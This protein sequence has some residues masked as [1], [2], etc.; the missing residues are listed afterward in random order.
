MQS[1]YQGTEGTIINEGIINLIIYTCTFPS[2]TCLNVWMPSLCLPCGP[3]SPA[4]PG[5]P[6]APGEPLPGEPGTP[7]SPGGPGTPTSPNFDQNK[8][9]Q[10][11]TCDRRWAF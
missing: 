11:C 7:T 10:C 5:G 4:G 8:E 1:Q 6:G 3:D 2:G 9:K